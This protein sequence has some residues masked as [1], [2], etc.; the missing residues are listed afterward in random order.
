MHV[1]RALVDHGAEELLQVVFEAIGLTTRGV[2]ITHDGWRSSLSV[3]HRDTTHLFRGGHS[4]ENLG[5]ST[6]T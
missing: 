4:L 2:Q 1:A 5:N 6:H 3:S